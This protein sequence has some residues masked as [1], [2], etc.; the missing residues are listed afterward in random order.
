MLNETNWV[1]ETEGKPLCEEWNWDTSCMLL[2]FQCLNYLYTNW[3]FGSSFSHHSLKM[4]VC[5]YGMPAWLRESVCVRE[6]WAEK[7]IRGETIMS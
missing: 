7:I 1:R 4:C 6:R 2:I 3:S 5:E